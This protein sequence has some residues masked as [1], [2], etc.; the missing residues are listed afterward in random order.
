MP[1]SGVNPATLL[2]SGQTETLVEGGPVFNSVI[3]VPPAE[4]LVVSVLAGSEVGLQLTGPNSQH[5]NELGAA[6]YRHFE[7]LS[8]QTGPWRLEMWTKDGTFPRA[9]F[10]WCVDGSV[11]YADLATE[12]LGNQTL[13]RATVKKNG[14]PAIQAP[15]SVKIAKEDGTTT[16]VTLFDRRPARRRCTERRY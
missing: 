4:R 12:N 1:I 7:V 16:E 15:T 3:Q 10:S 5:P 13:F 6:P 2:R 11:C 9:E 14:L 8:P